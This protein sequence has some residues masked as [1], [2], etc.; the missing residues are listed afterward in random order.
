MCAFSYRTFGEIV[1]RN[2][3]K[4][5]DEYQSELKGVLKGLSFFW[6]LF[7]KSGRQN[8]EIFC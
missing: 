2:R 8:S 7:G 3:G 1:F 4:G 5:M 6:I